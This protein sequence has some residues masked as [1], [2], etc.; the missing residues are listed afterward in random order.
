MLHK[1]QQ[2]WGGLWS[3]LEL[4]VGKAIEC[5]MLNELLWSLGVKETGNGAV[6]PVE[7]EDDELVSNVQNWTFYTV[8]C[9]V[10]FGMILTVPWLLHFVVRNYY[11]FY[12]HSKLSYVGNEWEISYFR[13]SFGYFRGTLTFEKAM[14]ILKRQH[15]RVLEFLNLWDSFKNG[16]QFPF[17]LLILIWDFLINKKEHLWFNN[18]NLSCWQVDSCAKS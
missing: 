18:W 11:V 8:Q 6:R 2:V 4:R 15:F 17:A 10:C 5:P 3:S 1:P 12:R 13:R 16:T 9:W 7:A 14:D